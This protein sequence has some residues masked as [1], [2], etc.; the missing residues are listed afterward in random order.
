M[1]ASEISS[2]KSEIQGYLEPKRSSRVRSYCFTLNNWTPEEFE[3]IQKELRVYDY[4]VIG[5]EVGE[6]GT[7]HLQGFVFCEKK[8]SWAT[9]KRLMPRAA[10]FESKARG[11][12]MSN[13]WNYCKKDGDFV[14]YGV[15]PAQGKR[16]D[17]AE[18][19]E[20]VDNGNRSRLSLMREHDTVYANHPNYVTEYLARTRVEQIQPP[21]IELREWQI[22]LLQELENEPTDR[23]VHWIW[24]QESLTGKSTFMKYVAAKYKDQYLGTDDLNKRNILCA[25]DEQKIIHIDLA[26]DLTMEQ[27]NWLK[28]TIESLS[29]QK[30]HFSSK[31]Q[32]GMKYVKAHIVVTANQPPVDGL[33][34][35]YKEWEITAGQPYTKTNW[36]TKLLSGDN[37]EYFERHTYTWNIPLNCWSLHKTR[38]Y[39][40]KYLTPLTNPH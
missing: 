39:Q 19:R 3:E 27:R 30:L 26:R 28:S 38:V 29:D 11:K 35:R 18:F 10:I 16:T 31:Y 24:S 21:S 1:Q 32:S 20:A 5:K 25:Y 8:I 22:E 7:P 2:Y 33:P 40:A 9:L 37:K 14:E 13:A 12:K 4:F 6:S 17:L 23:V 15:P 36:A 34:Y